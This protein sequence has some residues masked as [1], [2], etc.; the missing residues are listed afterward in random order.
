ML[1]PCFLIIHSLSIVPYARLLKAQKLNYLGWVDFI[2][3]FSM[4]LSVIIFLLNNFSL[5][6]FILSLLVQAF[7]RLFILKIYL[8]RLISFRLD[9]LSLKIYKKLLIQFSSNLVVYVSFRIDQLV[10]VRFINL[11]VL[12][13]YSFLKQLLSY[14]INLITAIFSQT[15]VPYFSRFRTNIKF[16][17]TT[18]IQ[19]ITFIS[20]LILLYYLILFLMPPPF[21][22]ISELWNFSS[23]LSV[24]IMLMCIS[25][26][27]LDCLIITAVA[28]GHVLEQLKRNFLLLIINL[29]L[30][31][32]III[33]SI[34][35]Y[36]VSLSAMILI[37][38]FS[39]YIKVF[40]KSNN[41]ATIS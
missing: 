30:V 20:S 1:M 7:V 24:C 23:V 12:G 4:F 40:R 19:S 9:F 6:T 18:L 14:P 38:V 5:Y 15:V 35:I 10:I 29:L 39:I 34:E 25:R 8:G 21:K 41:K 36:L 2:G 16:V 27:F 26:I 28:T 11:E 33:Y 37:F 22:D 3:V 32:L 17:H 31:F 13:Q